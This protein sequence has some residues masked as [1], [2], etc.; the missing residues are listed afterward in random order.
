MAVNIDES[1]RI[2]IYGYLAEAS[3]K[4]DANELPE[5]EKLCRLA[6]GLWPEPK[7]DLDVSEVLLR[8]IVNRLR[9]IGAHEAALAY[10]AEFLESV[11]PGYDYYGPNFFIGTLQ[12]EQGLLDSAREY[13]LKA[14]AQSR[15]RCFVEEDPKYKKFFQQV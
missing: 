13:F 1:L 10:I 14:N 12:Y 8:A 3:K 15:G 5:A 7:G 2:Q 9:A 11:P 4:I 6:W